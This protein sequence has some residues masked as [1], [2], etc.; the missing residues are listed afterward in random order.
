MRLPVFAIVCRYPDLPLSCQGCERT[1]RATGDIN[2]LRPIR[3]LVA[4]PALTLVGGGHDQ[5][6]VADDNDGLVIG[7]GHLKLV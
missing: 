2:Q 5:T 3:Q 4:M 7:A 6:L 1:I